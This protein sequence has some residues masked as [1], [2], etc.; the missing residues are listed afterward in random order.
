MENK[1]TEKIQIR[2]SESDYLQILSYADIFARFQDAATSQSELF[3]YDASVLTPKGLFWV[4]SK[5]K[6]WIHERP[7]QGEIVEISTWPEKPMKI[8]G[9]RNYTIT[10][11][12]DLLIEATTEWV[13]LDRNTNRFFMI[14]DLYD[15]D[16]VFW[17]ERIMPEDFYRFADDGLFSRADLEALAPTEI[18]IQYKRSCYEGDRLLWYKRTD[19]DWIELCA[20]LEDQTNIFYARMR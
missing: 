18:E 14:N 16:F 7:R 20:K 19:G 6:V 10:R 13:I 3:H 17:P 2:P 4:T 15:P 1:Y 12:D 11:N 8:R 9:R 5:S